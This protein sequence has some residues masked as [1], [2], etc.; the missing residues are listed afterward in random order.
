MQKDNVKVDIVA[1]YGF[2]SVMLAVL[3]SVSALEIYAILGVGSIIATGSPEVQASALGQLGISFLQITCYVPILV[4]RV[5]VYISWFLGNL[6]ILRDLIG[7]LCSRFAKVYL[8]E[9]DL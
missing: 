4:M 3:L 6:Y 5:F 7:V 2:N 9:G 8:H 1:F